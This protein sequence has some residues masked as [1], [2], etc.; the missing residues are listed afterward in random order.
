MK[1]NRCRRVKTINWCKRKSRKQPT[2]VLARVLI[3]G[4]KKRVSASQRITI[5]ERLMN[6]NLREELREMQFR[7]CKRR[8][9]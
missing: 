5:S 8:G 1:G 4:E 9:K 3:R 6:I 7:M 2:A